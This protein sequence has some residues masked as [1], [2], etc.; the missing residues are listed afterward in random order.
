MT[1]YTFLS[2]IWL[3]LA[4]ATSMNPNSLFNQFYTSRLT[5]CSPDKTR[6]RQEQVM[7]RRVSWSMAR[8]RCHA[9]KSLVWWPVPIG[10]SIQ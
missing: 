4:T 6:I 8:E 5:E 1:S 10:I 9:A 2:F 7:I 3:H